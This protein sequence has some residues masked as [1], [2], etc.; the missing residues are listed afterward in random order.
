MTYVNPQQPTPTAPPYTYYEQAPA[1]S[2]PTYIYPEPHPQ[3][4]PYYSQPYPNP[5]YFGD[6]A[7]DLGPDMLQALIMNKTDWVIRAPIPK[8]TYLRQAINYLGSFFPSTQDPDNLDIKTQAKLWRTAGELFYA[9][10]INDTRTVKQLE[11]S[12]DPI[13][14]KF[15]ETMPIEH[16]N[17]E[18]CFETSLDLSSSPETLFNSAKLQFLNN[19]YESAINLFTQAGNQAKHLEKGSGFRIQSFSALCKTCSAAAYERLGRHDLALFAYSEA[20]ETDPNG[21]STYQDSLSRSFEILKFKP[22]KTSEELQACMKYD[23]FEPDFPAELAQHYINQGSM[24]QAMECLN[25]ANKLSVYY[26]PQTLYRCAEITQQLANC[27][28]PNL[29]M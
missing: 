17:A 2:A 8:D 28:N 5:G 9:R 20:S 25:K 23:S 12:S 3:P 10:I 6:P 26:K 14:N 22:Y 16:T 21:N 18:T 27:M 13:F 29:G 1:P 15:L 24:E 7:Y 4:P 11:S 19:D